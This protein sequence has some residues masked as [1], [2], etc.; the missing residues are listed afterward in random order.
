MYSAR[1]LEGYLGKAA[2]QFPVLLLTGARQVG[3]TT[4]LRHLGG[5]QRTCVSLDDPLVLRLAREDP[6]L[7]MQR[8]PAPVLI[9]EI[10]YAP[11]LLPYIKMAVDADRRPGSFWLTGSQQFHLMRNASESLA[12]RVAVL[13]LLGLS[14]RESV[15]HGAAHK[16]FLPTASFFAERARKADTLALKDLYTLIWKGSFP[17]LT[18]NA[19]DRDLFLGSYVRT[20]LQRDVRDLA[21]VGD[22]MAFLRFLRASAART[23]QLLNI[24]ELARDADVSPVT[25]KKWLS[26]LEASGLVYLLEPYFTNVTR[27]MVKAPKLY[28]L[29]T[30]LAAYLTE[31][32]SPDTLEAGAMSGPILETWIMGEL[33]KSWLHNGLRPPFYYYRDRDQKE[34][35]LLI[36]QDGTVFPLEIKKTASPDKRDIRHFAVLEK[37]GMPVGMGGV[38]CLADQA[39]PL[40]KTAWSVPASW[41]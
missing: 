36:I 30:G 39:L 7:F 3:K 10:Q 18:L 22:E 38:I 8:F 41:I 21:Q 33:L 23:G 37:L 15:G 13:H 32:S 40:D 24:S 6:A 26:I 20:Y 11:Q 16:P 1:T 27:R 5:S 25:G 14:R 17:A 2:A 9:D 28:F 31:W 12:G 29:D 4:L 34:I 19:V 35:D